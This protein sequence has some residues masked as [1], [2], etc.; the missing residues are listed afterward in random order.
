MNGTLADC[1]AFEARKFFH[2]NGTG[3]A[4]SLQSAAGFY[5]VSKTRFAVNFA[6]AYSP[7]KNA[8]GFTRLDENFLREL[9]R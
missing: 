5:P 1:A 9:R 7:K 3:S 8:Y 4:S 2:G 6:A